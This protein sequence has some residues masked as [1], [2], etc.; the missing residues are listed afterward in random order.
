MEKRSRKKINKRALAALVA[1]ISGI[2]L[3]FTG[4]VSHLA[5]HQLQSTRPFWM[6]A[7]IILGTIFTICVIWHIG[8]NSKGMANHI[9][10]LVGRPR[11]WA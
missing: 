6:A 8:F 2:G 5:G 3:P 9:R 4:L 7:H 11:L 1:L 10:G